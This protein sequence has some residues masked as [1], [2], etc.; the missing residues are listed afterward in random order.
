MSVEGTMG[1]RLA[2][3]DLIPLQTKAHLLF[4]NLYKNMCFRNNKLLDNVAHGALTPLLVRMTHPCV[5]LSCFTRPSRC[6]SPSTAASC[7]AS[8]L[9]NAS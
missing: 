9:R 6:L 2:Q 4:T 1:V 7:H 5:F 8:G 3:L